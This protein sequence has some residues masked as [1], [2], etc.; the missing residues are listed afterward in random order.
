MYRRSNR[1]PE[2]EEIAT[3]MNMDIESVRKNLTLGSTLMS[4]GDNL[5]SEDA[6]FMRY[7]KEFQT[8]DDHAVQTF[9][10][11]RNNIEKFDLLSPVEKR[12]LLCF[13][14]W[15]TKGVGRRI[16]DSRRIRFENE[17]CR[18]SQ[19]SCYY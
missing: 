5:T 4:E 19:N 16:R 8:L 2:L 15:M 12:F 18:G 10:L 17:T 9:H 1:A 7:L 6:A 3:R 13:M 14:I 11:L